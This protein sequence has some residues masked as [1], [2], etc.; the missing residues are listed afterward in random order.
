MFNQTSSPSKFKVKKIQA[1][2]AKTVD[3]FFDPIESS[4][5]ERNAKGGTKTSYVGSSPTIKVFK[6]K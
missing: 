4:L 3:S 1:K 2:T 6:L 5:T